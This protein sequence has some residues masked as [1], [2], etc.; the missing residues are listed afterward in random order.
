MPLPPKT[1]LVAA[2]D[3][4]SYLSPLEFAEERSADLE[5]V[6]AVLERHSAGALALRRTAARQ[7]NRLSRRRTG[8][9]S[10]RWATRP[11]HSQAL[12]ATVRDRSRRDRRRV[13]VLR[14]RAAQR[15]GLETE[16]WHARR[17]QMALVCGLRLPW[18]ASDR[19]PSS[20]VRAFVQ[21]CTLH[22][23]SYLRPLL[24]S[25]PPARLAALL[26]SISDARRPDLVR[27]FRAC[28][29]REVACMLHEPGAWPAKAVAPV[30]I[31]PFPGGEGVSGASAD[32]SSHDVRRMRLL[33]FVHAAAMAQAQS[34]LQRAAALDVSTPGA[35]VGPP[36]AATAPLASVVAG[37]EEGDGMQ[38]GVRVG[39]AEGAPAAE[40]GQAAPWVGS[41]WDAEA[42]PGVEVCLS[43]LPLVRF[44]LR[45]PRSH[46]LL[47]RALGEC[48]GAMGA[49]LVPAAQPLLAGGAAAPAPAAVP[50]SRA[51]ALAASTSTSASTATSAAAPAANAVATPHAPTA[52]GL[53]GALAWAAMRSL[54]SAA[55]LPPRVAISL[56]ATP[57]PHARSGSANR[58]ALQAG[59]GAGAQVEAGV[60]LTGAA[61]SAS[62][63]RLLRQLLYSWPEGLVSNELVD[64]A[65]AEA[66]GS[67]GAG[68]VRDGSAGGSRDGTGGSAFAPTRSAAPPPS[69]GWCPVL[70]VQEP[71]AA[72]PAPRGGDG[73]AA[74]GRQGGGR[75]PACTEGGLG[76]GWDLIA[77]ALHARHLWHALI[78]CGGRAVGLADVRASSLITHTPVYPFDFPDTEGG[79]QWQQEEG[80]ERRAAHNRRPPGRRPN[81]A[82]IGSAHPHEPGWAATLDRESGSLDRDLG[83]SGGV[84]P[85]VVT[86]GTHGGGATEA[87]ARP[88][89]PLCM[90]RGAGLAAALAPGR[91][92]GTGARAPGL[93]E[94]AIPRGGVASRPPGGAGQATFAASPCDVSILSRLPPPM[95]G[96]VSHALVRVLLRPCD[97]GRPVPPAEITMLSRA[98]ML[99]HDSI[100]GSPTSRAPAGS[101][102]PQRPYSPPH[103]DLRASAGPPAPALL[104]DQNSPRPDV[105]GGEAERGRLIGFVTH[106]GFDRV[107]GGGAALG[108]CSAQA[109][110]EMVEAQRAA[111]SAGGQTP[112]LV[113]VRN[114]FSRQVR[115]AVL[116]VAL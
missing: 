67:S 28:A 73:G 16:A 39:R 97:K 53:S 76:S 102:S 110:F 36:A 37:V 100:G 31:L 13:A 104:A 11:P 78:T 66:N 72:A 8:S 69:P 25:G 71:P 43:P 33:I 79:M 95:R 94:G 40:A 88:L 4:M 30:R 34:V 47:I 106:G 22:D 56:H 70:L 60:G 101:A 85:S 49:E 103:L 113:G 46:A 90:L 44:Q 59:P 18:R 6:S 12:A 41:P 26:A 21:G 93:A 3:S 45:G 83:A 64:A 24:I 9:A 112:L 14:A 87:P 77:P 62:E 81:H 107:R 86:M 58:E 114:P 42:A 2:A 15:G 116:A 75:G 74:E 68:G 105:E 29:T 20:S 65:A 115:L 19:A 32:Y 63:S 99:A 109:V 48:H 98:A 89:V 54:G 96:V 5:A 92:T 61:W 55:T 7:L 27:L 82:A 38:A 91:N 52:H 80:E 84:A 50:A 35:P 1:K 23:A 10:P 111:G 17:F 51:P 57:T 108:F